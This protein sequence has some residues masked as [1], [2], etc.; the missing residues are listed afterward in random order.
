[1]CTMSSPSSSSAPAAAGLRTL[2]ALPG[3]R[4]LLAVRWTSQAADGVFQAGLAWLVLLSPERQQSPAAVAGAAAL[5]LL[6][7]S[8]VGPFAG[9][10]LDRWR[11]RSVLLVGQLVRVL[12]VVAMAALGDRAGLVPVYA[13]AIVALAVNRFLLAAFS[14]GLPSVVPRPLLLP[15]NAL[16]PTAGTAWVVVGLG[17]GSALLGVTRDDAVDGSAGT[18]PV[19]ALAAVLMVVAAGLALRFGPDELG[20]R[21][22]RRTGSVAGDLGG[23]V[24]G[25]G[26]GVAHLVQRRPAGRALVMLGAHRWCFGLWS[27]QTALLVLD[28]D[29][30]GGLSATAVVAGCGAAGYVSAALVTPLARRRLTDTA[31]VAAVLVGSAAV[32]LAAA[33]VPGVPALAVAAAL[34]G[35]G[36]QSVKICVDT[37]VQR[38]VD[39]GFLGR[40]FAIYDVVFNV[41]FVAAAAVAALLVPAD[42]GRTWMVPVLSAAG[43]T[44]TALAYVRG[45][46]PDGLTTAAAPPPRR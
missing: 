7:F 40:S 24:R 13:L 44:L 1:M 27:V 37:A 5:I 6:P 26:A 17:V 23:V 35:L 28:R 4:R 3:L 33:P 25:L 21:D 31:W 15:A 36:A 18:V 46:A 45:A 8:L 38:G 2:L 43:L 11:R 9:V 42:G 29:A 22:V 32:A 41:T 20:P 14:A 30:G 16:A 39:D 19:L 34:L 12:L 10:L